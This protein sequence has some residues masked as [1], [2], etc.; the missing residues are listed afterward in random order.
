MGTLIV[1]LLCVLVLRALAAHRPDRS[2]SGSVL[3]VV[4][5]WMTDVVDGA[6]TLARLDAARRRGLDRPPWV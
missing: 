6:R 4:R 5:G 1:L 3:V 2:A